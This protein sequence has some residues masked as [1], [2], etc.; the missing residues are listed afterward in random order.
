MS[1]ESVETP[2]HLLLLPPTPWPVNHENLKAA[3]ETPVSH[4]LRGLKS[5]IRHSSVGAILDIAV[6][7]PYLHLNKSRPRR[8]LFSVVQSLVAGVYKLV[9]L[10]AAKNGINVEDSEGVDIRVLLVA[11]PRTKSRTESAPD[12]GLTIDFV[13]P[14]IQLTTLAQCQRRWQ[15]IYAVEGEEGEAFLHKYLIAQD[16]HVKIKKLPGGVINVSEPET[17]SITAS[18]D[19]EEQA[20]ATEP[21][22]EESSNQPRAHDHY[23]VA[24][25]GTFDHLH[26]GHKLLL[27]MF[28]FLVPSISQQ[29]SG[30]EEQQRSLTIGITGDELL[31]NKSH[32]HL[33]ESWHTREKAAWS[34]LQ[35]IMDFRAEPDATV[36]INELEEPGPNGH[37][38]NV[39][40]S[41]ELVL[42][43]TEIVDPFGP[44]I[45][46][47]SITALAV[48]AETRKGGKAVNDRR[49]E[50]GWAELEV[51]EVDVL[52]PEE[53]VGGEVDEEFKNKLSSTSIRK[54]LAAKADA[55]NDGNAQKGIEEKEEA[56][57]EELREGAGRVAA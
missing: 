8:E 29:N 40:L 49:V 24:V 14:V 19:V 55:R 2:A 26:I 15:H 56:A 10:I 13:G 32:H 35:S 39:R 22:D 18:D 43:F 33:L 11:H 1:A 42:K 21:S 9:C 34:F 4:A 27:T 5:D 7:M 37:V 51:F 53:E 54:S 52:S 12:K 6:P 45:T 30:S 23:S 3:Y 44:T 38:V 20:E 47:E 28:A 31:K 57:R 16:G 46:D 36:K 50:K 17:E 48:S 41:P 25:G